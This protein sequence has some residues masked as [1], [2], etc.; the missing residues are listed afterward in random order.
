MLHQSRSKALW[1]QI[2][3]VFLVVILLTPSF[4]FAQD[5]GEEEEEDTIRENPSR[6]EIA[7]KLEKVAEEKDIPSVILKTIAYAESTWRQW[8]DKGNVVT[9]GSETNPSYGIMQV[10]LRSADQDRIEELKD[11]IDYNITAGA[12]LLNEKFRIQ[13]QIGDG[14]RSKPEN[15]YFAIWAYNSWST[16]NNPNN[17]AARQEVSYQDMIIKKAATNYFP[18][19]VTPVAITP[20]D[21]A[22]IPIDT[23]PSDTEIWETPE[24]A[25]GE[26]SGGNT[27]R[28][29]GLDR[30]GTVNQVAL[31]G[32]PDGAETVIIA[33]SDDFPDAL[34]GVTL[35]KKYN[36]PIL[37]TSPSELENS[38]SKVLNKL[39]PQRIIILGGTGAI[40]ADVE[41]QIKKG[42]SWTK[43]IERIAGKNRYETAALIAAEIPGTGEIAI[44]TGMNFPDALTMAS[45][46]AAKDIPIL[47]TQKDVLPDET[48]KMIKS[49]PYQKIYVAGGEG[50][51][52]SALT[53][54]LTEESGISQKQIIRLGGE[55]RYETSVK[56]IQCFFPEAE[57]LYIADGI[58]FC[59]PLA[60]G[61]L[62][63][64][65][66]APLLIV[67]TEGKGENTAL[68]AYL[69]NLSPNVDLKVIGNEEIITDSLVTLLE[70][71]MRDG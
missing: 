66:Q 39:R 11:D 19:L 65:K 59:S 70:K 42:A 22:L 33:R 45:A 30:I 51:I 55:D 6:A 58:D 68:E 14:D 41:K 62:A 10:S 61:A 48:L 50:V 3:A 60:A 1:R 9:G 20:V 25:Q 49:S 38:V 46:A 44:A 54:Q 57:E 63:A 71:K 32:W 35:A 4:A 24:P 21:P 31:T 12:D 7:R 13:P 16:G 56:T 40:S 52:S 64:S 26:E 43:D 27:M 29:A 2:M 34:A 8:D 5:N 23:L 53:D 69:K 36:A 28:I 37:V 18:G 17:A 15:W 67:R 47:L